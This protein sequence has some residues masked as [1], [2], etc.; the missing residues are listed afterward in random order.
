VTLR[1]PF[2]A[3]G[4]HIAIGLP[5]ATALFTTRRGGVSRGPYA[6]LNLGVLT[7]DERASVRANQRVVAEAV[8]IPFARFARGMQVHA[9]TVRSLAGAPQAGAPLEPADGQATS[10]PDVAATVLVADCLPVALAGDGA[11]AMLHCGWRG[12]ADGIVAE[13]VRAVREL[14]ATGE[15]EAAIGPGIGPCCFEV[16]DEVRERFAGHGE[17]VR[18]GRNLDLK[19]IARRELRAAGVGEVSDVG[20]CTHCGDPALFFSHRRDAG[21]TGRQAGIAWLS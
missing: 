14:G 18:N 15:L 21:V 12:L 19:E 20:L 2:R 11:V 16:G 13:G 4:E 7:E 17:E 8:G 1:A 6:S 3:A 10:A 9:T 5:G